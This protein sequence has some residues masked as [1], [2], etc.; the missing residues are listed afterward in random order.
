MNPD[1]T[2][3]FPIENGDIPAM[4]VLSEDKGAKFSKKPG[5]MI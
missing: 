1:W 3:K 2:C 4:L 5:E